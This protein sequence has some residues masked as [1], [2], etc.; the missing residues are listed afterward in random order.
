MSGAPALA[1]RGA[2][3]AGAGL[4]TI[5]VPRP[6][7]PVVAGFLP[8]AMSAALPADD[9]GRLSEAAAEPLLGLVERADVVVVGPGLGRAEGTQAAVRAFVAA[10]PKPL[11]LD[12]DGL[13]AYRGRLRDLAARTAPSVLTP[14]EGEA[15]ALLEDGGEPKAEGRE[16]RAARIARAAEAVCVLKGPGTVVCDGARV[17]ENSTGGPVLATGGTG[18]VLS[19]VLAAL[20]AAFL[21]TKVD[22]FGAACLAVHVHGAAGDRLAARRG[23]RGVLASEVADEIPFVLRARARARRRK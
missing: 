20:L 13:Q 12:A 10:C 15:A 1:A 14:H 16:P 22:A 11:V 17:R 3:R 4:V 9:A 6:V 7:Q 18:D 2:L 8:E 5:A 21:P 19:G 23:D